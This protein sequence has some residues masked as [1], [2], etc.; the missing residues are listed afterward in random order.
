M[1]L[2][3][4]RG[5]ALAAT[6]VLLISGAGSAF[7]AGPAPV[8]LAPV[9]PVTQAEPAGPDTDTLQ[10]G[11][12]TTPDVAGATE[13]AVEAGRQAP[14]PTRSRWATRPRR[15]SPAPPSRP[16]RSPRRRQLRDAEAPEGYRDAGRLRRPWRPRGS[17]GSERRPPVQRRGVI[18]RLDRWG[19]AT[20]RAGV[21]QHRRHT[22]LDLHQVVRSD[23][24][25]IQRFEGLR[26]RC[27]EVPNRRT[28]TAHPDR[29][30]RGRDRRGRQG[31]PGR[32]WSCRGHRR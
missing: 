30:R 14:T 18:P 20:A 17:R 31:R 9:A 32:G 6:A 10:V 15:T 21:G 8:A 23:A 28:S 27:P 29:G 13:S 26:Y 22:G 4:F 16:S 1:K 12:Q 2:D 7:A 11:D 5:P 25:S 19:P 24:R 3:R